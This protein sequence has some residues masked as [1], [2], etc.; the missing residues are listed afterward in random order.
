MKRMGGGTPI[1]T[2][3]GTGCPPYQSQYPMFIAQANRHKTH[4]TTDGLK[5]CIVPRPVLLGI[6]LSDDGKPS[7]VKYPDQSQWSQT[8]FKTY[9]TLKGINKEDYDRIQ[10]DL[11]LYQLKDGTLLQADLA[12]FEGSKLVTHNASNVQTLCYSHPV[13]LLQVVEMPEFREVPVFQF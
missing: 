6:I 9:H 3:I 12:A 11:V 1:L 4:T 2:Y 7:A 10:P 13:N 5:V 8:G